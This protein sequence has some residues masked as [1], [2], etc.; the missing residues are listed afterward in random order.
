MDEKRFDRDELARR[1]ALRTQRTEGNALAKEL[2]EEDELPR[3]SWGETFAMVIAAYQVLLP[4]VLA[5][6]GVMGLL[7]LFFKYAF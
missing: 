7:W 6:V 4:P 2:D 1:R 5:I 3:F